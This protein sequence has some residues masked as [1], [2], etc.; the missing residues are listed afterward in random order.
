[1]TLNN[2]NNTCKWQI[3]WKNYGKTMEKRSVTGVE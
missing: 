1:M 2:K 3:G